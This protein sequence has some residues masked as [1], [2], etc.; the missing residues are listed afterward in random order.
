MRLIVWILASFT[1]TTITTSGFVV[2]PSQTVR[3]LLGR[4][5][6][7]R[8][9]GNTKQPPVLI[10]EIKDISYGEESRQYRRTVFSHDDWRRFRS[11]DRFPVNLISM[12]KSGI[13]KNLAREV[14]LGTLIAAFVVVWNALAG[15]YVDLQGIQ[16]EA[17][18]SNLMLLGLPQA[19]FVLVSPAL[20]LLLGKSVQMLYLLLTARTNISIRS[21]STQ[22]FAPALATKGG[23]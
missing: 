22:C 11:T 7:T 23:Y 17:V 12:T 19:P 18:F 9:H 13:Y 6:S 14:T 4:D 3:V 10:P 16:H 1:W 5:G 8:L 20:S 15:G 2:G 21:S